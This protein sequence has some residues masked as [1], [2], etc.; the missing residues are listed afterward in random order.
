MKYSD[1]TKYFVTVSE[2]IEDEKTQNTESHGF[3]YL[4]INYYF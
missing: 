3:A 2:V 4:H 1:R